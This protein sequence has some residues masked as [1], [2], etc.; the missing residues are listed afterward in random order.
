MNEREIILKVPATWPKEELEERLKRLREPLE[1]ALQRAK[2]GHRV[3]LESR[4]LAGLVDELEEL[5]ARVELVEADRRTSV[6]TRDEL[7]EVRELVA[8]TAEATG[9][10]LDQ[11]AALR[12]QVAA[13]EERIDS[14]AKSLRDGGARER[15][16]IWAA[17]GRQRKRDA[18]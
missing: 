1:T 3:E 10:A 16:K 8:N 2:S 5:R 18:E 17:I 12:V 15:G 4:T 14:T 13:A 9:G 7:A 11:A 6:A